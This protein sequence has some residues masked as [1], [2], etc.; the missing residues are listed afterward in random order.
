MG[1]LNLF[2][3]QQLPERPIKEIVAHYY[4]HKTTKQVRSLM[5]V[6]AQKLREAAPDR[7]A[8]Y[9]VLTAEDVANGNTAGL[10]R[11]KKPKKGKKKKK[12]KREFGEK[13]K[14]KKKS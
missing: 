8:L 12:K 4:S 10:F 11:V 7:L 2:L 5:D 13:K 14:K 3:Q 6:H 1:F 9:R